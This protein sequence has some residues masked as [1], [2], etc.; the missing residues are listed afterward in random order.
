MNGKKTILL[1]LMI[2]CV[3]VSLSGCFSGSQQPTSD[4][5]PMIIINHKVIYRVTGY[6]N[7]NTI[8]EYAS[9]TYTNKQGGT[10]QISKAQLPWSKTLYPMYPGDFV[11]ISAQNLDEY[12]GVTVEIWLDG[13]KMKSSE[14][15]GSYVIATASGRI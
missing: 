15:S 10:E 1:S 11:Y 6:F 2:T 12:G 7:T 9:L 5:E 4:D 3:T 8:D 13:V 14:S